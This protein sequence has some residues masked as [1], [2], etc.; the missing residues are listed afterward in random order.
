MKDNKKRGGWGV[1]SQGREKW[2]WARAGAAQGSGAGAVTAP[3]ETGCEEAGPGVVWA[4][5]E[6]PQ[7]DSVPSR[8]HFLLSNLFCVLKYISEF[9][10]WLIK[11]YHTRLPSLNTGAVIPS[12]DQEVLEVTWG[13]S[14][15]LAQVPGWNQGR[16]LA[17]PAVAQEAASRGRE[18]FL[19]GFYDQ[20]SKRNAFRENKAGLSG[21]TKF[22]PANLFCGFAFLDA[23]LLPDPSLRS[24]W[25]LGTTY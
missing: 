6:A 3:V 16:L 17:W 23:P 13:T 5:R 14:C 11:I 2:L 25:W 19:T 8:T 20:S 21:C 18:G 9:L 4:G 22:S 1:G 24:C 10:I 7:G 15:L 12:G